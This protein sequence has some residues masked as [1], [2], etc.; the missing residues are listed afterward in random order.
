[1]LTLLLLA[2][3]PAQWLGPPPPKPAT[4]V[5]TLAPSLTETVLALGAKDS[6]VAVSRFC[7]FAEVAG[8]PRAG[9]F[10]DLAVETIVALKPHLLVVQK[11]PA[12]QK[13][14][15][16][17]ARLGVPVLA[18]PLTTVDDVAVAMTALGEALGRGAEAR[19]LVD[20]LG[21]ARAEARAVKVA[22]GRRVLFVVGFAPLVVAGPG[23]FADE[24]LRDCGVQNAAER[25]PTA[26]PTY[27]L[28]RAVKLAPDVVVDAADVPEGRDAV[29]A[30]PP[31]K[32]AR[33]VALPTKD[34]LHPG[35][36]LAKALPAL[37]SAVR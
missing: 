6:L 19:G 35:P 11:A 30:L 10:N 37:C 27:S 21:R 15:E 24:L 23:S 7:E 31:L 8:L 2:A 29:E 32:R 16:T 28:E 18:L 22:R 14:V 9:G 20:E 5:V 34:V 33:W 3:T 12:N 4:R 13:A 36:A 26:Y 1:M 25:A 17:L